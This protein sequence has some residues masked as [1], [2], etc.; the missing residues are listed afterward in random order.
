M[1]YTQFLFCE[2]CGQPFQLDVDF[3]ATVESY[4]KDGRPSP[5]INSPTVIW[6]YLIYS[7]AQCKSRF[8]Y[9]FR[10]VEKRVRKYLSS[11]GLKYEKYLEELTKYQSNEDARRTGDFFVDKDQKVKKRIE[12]IYSQQ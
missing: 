12:R 8:K 6:D 3:M 4:S 7:C 10:D 9:T 11:V 2:K 1:P 5:Q